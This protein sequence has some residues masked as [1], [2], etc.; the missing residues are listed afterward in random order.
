MKEISAYERDLILAVTGEG[1]SPL[2]AGVLEK[3][4]VVTAVLR[5]L[6]RFQG[7]TQLVFCGGTCLAKAHRRV[8]RMSEDVDF[9]IRPSPGTSGSARRKGR[10][11]LRQALTEHLRKDGFS[12]PPET[13]KSRA[14]NAKVSLQAEYASRF[15]P[16]ASLRPEIQ[17]QWVEAMPRLPVETLEVR[18]LLAEAA[19]LEESRFTWSCV[20][21][22]ET[23]VEKVVA[24]LRRL[25]SHSPADGRSTPGEFIRHIYDVAMSAQKPWKTGQAEESRKV[26]WEATQA[27]AQEFGS[28]YPEFAADPARKMQ[29][30]LSLLKTDPGG[31]MEKA[32]DRFAA[33]MV[34]GEKPSYAEARK[35]FCEIAED[36]LA[37]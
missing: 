8:Q 15:S 11:E 17:V 26:F 14:A 5:S 31:V 12:I 24:L 3:D 30:A 29:H 35:A 23:T 33:D 19:G 28:R 32:Y 21:V 9:K 7:N 1:R 22:A 20:S 25:G 13:V 16:V 37:T 34:F 18:S 27:D 6:A 36:W 4:L 10:G 2:P